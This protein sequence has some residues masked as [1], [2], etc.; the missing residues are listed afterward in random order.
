MAVSVTREQFLKPAERRFKTLSYRPFGEIR[1][2]SLL[3]SEMRNLRESMQDK[4][5]ELIRS[6][7]QRLNQYLLAAC[8]VNE[9]GD[10]LLSDDDVK[11]GAMDQMDGQLVAVLVKECRE[12]T[13]FGSDSDWQAI[14]DAAKNSEDTN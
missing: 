2:R 6:R 13:G 10:R 11:S 8:L 7:S 5:G 12:W 9:N 4:R 3:E 14:E 1:I